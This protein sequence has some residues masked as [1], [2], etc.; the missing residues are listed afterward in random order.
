MNR[1]EVRDGREF[2]FRFRTGIMGVR[3]RICYRN[4]FDRIHLGR[5]MDNR[6][7]FNAGFGNHLGLWCRLRRSGR[8]LLRG[9]L[10]HRTLKGNAFSKA[11][12]AER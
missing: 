6:D 2:M 1:R 10:S 11:A 5:L 3:H 8:R 4:R 9:H 7:V 12:N